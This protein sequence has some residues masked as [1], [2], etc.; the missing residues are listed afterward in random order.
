VGQANL[1]LTWEFLIKEFEEKLVKAYYDYMVDI[2]VLFGA[3]KNASLK[4]L[5]ETLELEITIAN[6]TVT[7]EESRTASDFYRKVEDLIADYPFIPLVEYINNILMIITITKQEN[8]LVGGLD[9]LPK[10]G[11]VLRGTPKRLIY[12]LIP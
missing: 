7:I 1:G 8:V 9:F 11:E 3:D 10:I 6:I 2:A 12:Q 5:K 4:K